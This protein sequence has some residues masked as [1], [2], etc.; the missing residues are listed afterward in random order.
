MLRIRNAIALQSS[1]PYTQSIKNMAVEIISKT[2]VVEEGYNNSQPHSSAELETGCYHRVSHQSSSTSTKMIFGLFLPSTYKNEV[3]ANTPVVFWLS[4]LTCDDTNFAMKAGSRAFDAAEKNGMAIVLPDTSPRHDASVPNVDSYDFG[5]GAGFYVN[6][7]VEPYSQHYKMYDYV[8][9]E[10]PD[11]LQNELNIGKHGL[12][13]ICGHS[14]GGHGALTIALREVK[15]SWKSVSAFAPIANPVDCPW[16]QKAFEGYLGS[17][18]A[19]K[20][21]DATLLVE[22]P[23]A[24]M[25]EDILIDQ[26]TADNF[27]EEQLK[28]EALE[29][30]AKRS[31]QKITVNMRNGFDHSY[32]FIAQ[33]IENHINFHAKYL[34]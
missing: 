17:V 26:G 33:F 5:I 13:S 18:D 28:P 31:G 23:Q 15:D 6:A 1:R 32:Y 24:P 9:A 29:V 14:M 8:T 3:T 11:I 4:G 34:A 30:A 12:K 7:S 21:Y 22:S 19:G 10:L 27:L 20:A 25:Y 2:R 16:G